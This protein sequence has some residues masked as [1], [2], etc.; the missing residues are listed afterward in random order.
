[1][2]REGSWKE[3]WEATFSSSS[4]DYLA[5]RGAVERDEGIDRLSTAE[6]LEFIDPG[7]NDVV[8]DAGCGTGANIV[9]LHNRVRQIIAVDFAAAAVQRA[10]D[11]AVAAGVRNTTI[12]QGDILRAGLSDASV[13]KVLC[14]SVFHYLSDEQ[15]RDCLRLFK[16]VLRNDGILI[17]HVKNLASVYLS[18][19][20]MMKAILRL[21][22]RRARLN[23]HFRTFSWY[24][25]E[26]KAAG[27]EI[28]AFNSFNVMIVE[29]MPR[30]LITMLQRIELRHRLQF[31]FN[32]SV[33]RRLGADLKIRARSTT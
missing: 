31:P 19:L 1:M 20:Q 8:F 9:L 33:L 22:G 6:L 17:L 16:R 2:K 27:F 3:F 13:D 23:E 12:A 10:Q 25:H 21:C 18:T 32:T 7:P 5:D 30:S 14:L 26:L 4:S 24:R 11:R 29:R 28:D 15:V